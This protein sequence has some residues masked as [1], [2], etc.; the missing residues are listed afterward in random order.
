M[1][2][3]LQVHSY[4]KH[5]L[6][7]IKNGILI[8]TSVFKIIVDGIV[9]TRISKKKDHDFEEILE[10]LDFIKMNNRWGKFFITPHV[11]TEVCNHL[12]NDYNR[13]RNYKQIINEIMP[14]LSQMEDKI[15]KKDD[16]LK[17]IDLKNPIIE[18]GD[19]SIFVV[20]EDF[21]NRNEKIAILAND[22]ELNKKYEYSSGILLLNYKS[23]MLNL[24]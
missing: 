21:I 15:V 11:L 9:T 2:L 23:N 5:I 7:Y 14:I 10:F 18:V 8:D 13:W 6:P 12:R 22:R 16:V 17:L 20:A 4:D 1:F 19:L 3:N 24:L